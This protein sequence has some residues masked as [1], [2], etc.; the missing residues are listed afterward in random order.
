MLENSVINGVVNAELFVYTLLIVPIVVSIGLIWRYF[1]GIKTMSINVFLVLTYA[2][3]FLIPDSTVMSIILGVLISIYT[4]F[5]AYY[6]KKLTLNLQLHYW[7]RISVVILLVSAT[8][9][10]LFFATY[11]LFLQNLVGSIRIQPLGIILLLSL[12]EIFASQQIQKG[13][14]TARSLFI[15]TLLVSI[16]GAFLISLDGVQKFVLSNPI[17]SIVFIILSLLIGRYSGMRLTEYLR[18]WSVYKSIQHDKK[19]N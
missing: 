6:L 3:A 18:F 2:F 13:I 5:I 16:S 11:Y 12:T 17:I 15:N 9:F 8:I 7:A 14:K 4:F 1:I 19:N 10:S